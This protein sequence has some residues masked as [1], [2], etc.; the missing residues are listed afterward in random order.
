MSRSGAG[1]VSGAGAGCGALAAAVGLC[2]TALR[3]PRPAFLGHRFLKGQRTPRLPAS[4]KPS[5]PWTPGGPKNPQPSSTL[6]RAYCLSTR[7]SSSPRLPG[8]EL[9]PVSLFPLAFV[10]V[11]TPSESASSLPWCIR[12]T[13]FHEPRPQSALPAASPVCPLHDPWRAAL[14]YAGEAPRRSGL[15]RVTNP[16]NSGG[17]APDPPVCL[18]ERRCP[19]PMTSSP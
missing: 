12:G 11:G 5:Q 4:R 9:S 17:G 18:S 1:D 19:L 2:A 6:T 3:P 7:G 8:L 15:P 10:R 16:G 14:H 13:G